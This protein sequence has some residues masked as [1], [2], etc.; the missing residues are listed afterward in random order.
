MEHG[1]EHPNYEYNLA[2]A[3]QPLPDNTYEG[4]NR[5]NISSIT[6]YN[7]FFPT[8]IAELSNLQIYRGNAIQNVQVSPIQYD[9]Q[10]HIVRVIRKS[11]IK[12]VLFKIKLKQIH[13]LK[14]NYQKLVKT[15]SF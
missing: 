9:Y 5:N 8:K 14:I 1:T 4:Y 2:P 12:L 10:N 3:R 15:T 13:Q 6:P 11:S 7:G